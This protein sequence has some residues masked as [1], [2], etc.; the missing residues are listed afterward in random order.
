MVMQSVYPCTC[1]TVD[2]CC[3]SQSAHSQS[4]LRRRGWAR[5]PSTGSCCCSRWARLLTFISS[6]LFWFLT[7]WLRHIAMQCKAIFVNW[8][9]DLP[10]VRVK[11]RR[12]TNMRERSISDQGQLA[13][14][15]S[16]GSFCFYNEPSLDI[17]Y[18]L[19]PQYETW[20][21]WGM[22]RIKVTILSHL[23]YKLQITLYFIYIFKLRHVYVP[24]VFLSS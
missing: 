16:R 8:P 14:I 24:G 20:I 1:S 23:L 10:S 15:N 4:S 6:I 21:M 11:K 2:P 9:A 7:H 19:W 12:E 22:A 3:Q 5:R 13:L 18:S 17:C